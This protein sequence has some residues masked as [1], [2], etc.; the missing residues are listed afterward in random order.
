M[1]YT[2]L[3]VTYFTI[4]IILRKY[5]MKKIAFAIL[6]VVTE[7]TSFGQSL[8]FEN[9]NNSSWTSNANISDSIIKSSKEI[10]L[11]RLKYSKDSINENVTMWNF[12]DS[13]LTILKYDYKAKTESIVASYKYEEQKD[14]GILQLNIDTK[15]SVNYGIGIAS[16]GYSALLI[17]KKR[18]KWKI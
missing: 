2:S 3:G 4:R 7:L 9:L 17:R 5:K 8:F 16:S 12:K 6:F 11:S 10:Q 15:F 1:K 13:V 18:I 14:K